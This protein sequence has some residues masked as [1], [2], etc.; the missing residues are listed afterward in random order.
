MVIRIFKGPKGTVSSITYDYIHKDMAYSNKFI[1][2]TKNIDNIEGSN[3]Y[4]VLNDE[5]HKQEKMEQYDNFKSAQ[6]SL[7]Q[8][9]MFNISTAGKGS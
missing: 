9:L 4:V 5:L 6:I 3:P 2:Q 1:V 7:P 8:P